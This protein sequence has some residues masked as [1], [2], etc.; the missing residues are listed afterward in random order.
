MCTNRLAWGCKMTARN[1]LLDK[2][3]NSSL[4]LNKGLAVLFALALLLT[5]VSY[6]GVQRMLE[7]QRENVGVHF[8]RLM[9]NIRE[10]ESF[11]NTVSRESTKGRL[12]EKLH[13][14]INLHDPA[15]EQGDN[16]YVGRE[17][18]F[19][20][21]F[22][23]RI[24]PS[25]IPALQNSKITELGAHLANYYSAY[26]SASHY[27]SPQTYVFNVP[28]NFE[29]S[30]PAH[31][32]L[33]GAAH[34]QVGESAL[35]I[36]QILAP[37]AAST[38]QPQDS[39][40]HWLQYAS[41]PE[42]SGAPSILSYVDIDLPAT[43]LHISGASPRVVVASLLNLAQVSNVQRIMQR[44]VYD[45]FV[46]IAP[47]GEPVV[48][49]PK[50]QSSLHDGLNLTRDGLVFQ[51]S[52]ADA[53]PWTG[54]YTISLKTFIDYA[55]WAL[56]GLL[57][58]LLVGLGCGLAFSRWYNNRVISP[59]RQAH[60]AIAEREAFSRAVIES[61]PTGLCVLRHSDHQVLLE[62]H[63]AL[64]SR[65]TAALVAA[66]GNQHDLLT[67]GKTELE[68]DGQHLQVSFVFTRYHGEDAWLCAFHDVTRHIEDA[69]VLE[70]ARQVADSANQAKSR[71]LAT[72]SH[73]IRTPLYGVLGTLELLELTALQPR[74]QAYLRTIQR[75]SSTLFQLI[76][77]V[78]DVSKIE[79][80]Q[81]TIDVQG[82]CPLDIT[83]EVM[84]TYSAFAHSKGLRLYACIDAQLPD[85]V[86]GDPVRIRQIL[87]NL[88]SNAI[89]FT[90]SGQ[91]VLWVRLLEQTEA[92]SSLEWQV[93]DSGIGISTEQ[94]VQLF[95]PFYQ[96]RNTFSEGGAG[97]GL[98]ICR[99]LCELMGATLEVT[100]EPGLGSSFALHLKLEREPGTLTD[101]PEFEPQAGP[102]YVRAPSPELAQHT[103]A[104]LRRLGVHARLLSNDMHSVDRSTLLVDMLASDNTSDWPGPRIIAKPDGR[105]PPE[106]TADGWE[107]DA[108]SIRAIAWAVS[109]AQQG[110]TASVS[111]SLPGQDQP[112]QLRVLVAED[113]PIN[114]EII[115]EQLEA[116]GCSVMV[117]T[118]GEQALALWMPGLFDLVLTD[119]NMPVLNGYELAIAL[120]SQ[121]RALP[122]I[123]ITANAMREEGKRC[124]AAGMNAW[125]VKPLSMHTL[126]AQLLKHCKG[127]LIEPGAMTDHPPAPANGVDQVQLSPR[128]RE[129]FF[130]TM[131]E[132]VHMTEV[133][134]DSGNPLKL[135]HQLHS[136]GGALGSVQAYALADTCAELERQLGESGL[137]PQLAEAVSNWLGS[138]GT[139]LKNLEALET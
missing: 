118:N 115:K 13:A 36:R 129:L 59:A 94:Q 89:K 120:R 58:L 113:N 70:Q 5:G 105:N 109:F 60:D 32:R 98:S 125:M 33:R 64:Q 24:N 93:S 1:A 48:G 23:V 20:L 123:G 122:I 79:A 106:F 69:T 96:V 57:A 133:A 50:P 10:H 39:T 80:G 78:L 127:V 43:Q 53:R 100:S 72:M 21:P 104:W 38:A 34:T 52:S 6:W 9:E 102:V 91:V 76:S 135:A 107:A 92:Y 11:L 75:S 26:W 108:N 55:L 121:D 18:S 22:S 84:R 2:L 25:T 86:R 68:I 62:N 124:T 30:V 114:R 131:Y 81:M 35:V 4:H 47:N 132:D 8:A 71:F 77:D 44:S 15:P 45:H 16:V 95:E 112:L 119:V 40:V 134:L 66:L 63:L 49:T 27:Q 41:R 51:I 128:M 99:R 37:R 61:A 103:C 31:G 116:L 29:I 7:E 90:D 110:I 3:A 97:L 138:I 14:P 74:Q 12:L 101:C 126:H 56:L 54:I 46:L 137:T 42:N 85:R 139:L 28:D 73:E 17:Y 19:S 136:M 111:A 67:H 87:N 117:A 65:G 83:E 88:L 82:F 130:N